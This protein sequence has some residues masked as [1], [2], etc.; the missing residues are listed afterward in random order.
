MLTS[1][2]GSSE[3]S[4][5]DVRLTLRPA[6]TKTLIKGVIAI[7][8]FSL[9]LEIASNLLNYLIF[10]ALSFAMVGLYMLIKHGSKFMIGEDNI[11]IKRIF[12]KS[13]TVSYQDIYDISV[14]QGILARRFGCGSVY[15][16]LKRGRGGVNLMGGGTA[17]KLEDVPDPN[18]VFELI[19][20]KLSP[21]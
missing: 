11:Q 13:N 3:G 12:G 19:S 21:F 15:M 2:A 7:A 1:P 4:E 5:P 17:E 8:V 14:A 16:I 18:H 10:L 6:V 9:F 20:S